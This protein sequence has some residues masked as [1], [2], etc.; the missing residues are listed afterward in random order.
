M[1]YNS[2]VLQVL[3]HSLIGKMYFKKEQTQTAQ[4]KISDKDI[5]NFVLPLLDNAVNNKIEK[6]YLES[7]KTKILSKHLL[8]IAKRGVEMAIE[9]SE[10]EA[11]VWIQSEL[12]K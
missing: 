6:H 7:Q 12:K 11:Q 9:K 3:L 5:H 4:P 1:N 10:K 2:I 8:Y